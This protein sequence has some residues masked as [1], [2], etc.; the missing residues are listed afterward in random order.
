[1][2]MEERGAGLTRFG[3]DIIHLLNERKVFTDVSHLSV[4]AF[5]ETLEQAEFV[6]A[7]HSSAKA[8]CAHPRNLDDEQ[9]KA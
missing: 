4:K 9:I 6:I 3:K 2:I 5:W 1:G 8:I 7:S